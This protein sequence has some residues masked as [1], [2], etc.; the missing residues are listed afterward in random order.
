RA[1]DLDAL[2]ES[3]WALMATYLQAGGTLHV[4]GLRPVWEGQLTRVCRLLKVPAPRL[5]ETPAMGS[6]SFPAERADFAR[7][8]AG[9]R[10]EAPAGRT[11]LSDADG[12]EAL[13]HGEARDRRTPVMVRRRLGRGALVFSA[14]P[15]NLERELREAFEGA[16][17]DGMA[18]VLTLM[19]LR[20]VYGT[21]AWHAPAVL[22]N[23]T[24]DD[25]ALRRG[26]LGP[27]WDILLGRARDHEFHV[28]IATVPREL[29]LADAAVVELM[30]RHRG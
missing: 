3:E 4:D 8:L 27:R 14:A 2:P 25:P 10:L 26:L 24:I 29:S 5:V 13:A 11:G 20:A 22:A 17:P 16:S 28:T 7:V 30:R 9:T 12:W 18:A 1:E 19:V 21:A 6:L 23:F 15:S